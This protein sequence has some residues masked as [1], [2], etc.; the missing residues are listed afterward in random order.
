MKPTIANREWRGLKKLCASAKLTSGRRLFHGDS[1]AML[2]EFAVTASLL[3]M[4]AFGI[5]QTC[6]AMYAFEFVT[7]AAAIAARY[8]AV[9]GSACTGISNCGITSAAIN[10]YVQGIAYPGIDS[11]NLSA[12]ATWLSASASQPTTWTACA[13]QCNATGNAV[14]VQ[15]KYTVPLFLPYWKSTSIPVSS[16]AQMVIVN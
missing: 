5:V 10:T 12:T 8:A 7:D 13:N 3:F 14:K 16:S 2:V 6:L 11:S 15:V 9:R 1:G 4:L